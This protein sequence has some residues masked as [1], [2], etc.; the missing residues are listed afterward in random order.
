[1]APQN[2]NLVCPVTQGT[3]KVLP[4]WRQTAVIHILGEILSVENTLELV[5][6]RGSSTEK[7]GSVT[8]EIKK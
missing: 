3:S 6:E 1:M 5:E 8:T 2:G 4:T 7:K